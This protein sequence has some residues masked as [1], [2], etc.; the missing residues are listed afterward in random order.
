MLIC[1]GLHD[2]FFEFPVPE[3]DVARHC[4]LEWSNIAMEGNLSR[5]GGS[6][7]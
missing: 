2:E 7:M 6:M 5:D 3:E 4:I 1:M